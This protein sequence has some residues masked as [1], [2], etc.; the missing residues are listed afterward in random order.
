MY[1]SFFQLNHKPFE[2]VPNPSFLFMSSAHRKA[3]NYLTYGIRQQS[4]FI[5]LTGEVG[6]GKTT[7]IRGLIKSQLRDVVLSKV[8]NTK[9][10]SQQLLEMILEDFGVRP[11][12]KDK[13][14]LLRELNDFLIEQYSRGRQCVLI[15]DEAQNLTHELLE[16]V[17]LLSNLENDNQKLLR[18]ILVGQPELKTLL[19]S[20]KLLQL[21]QRVQVNCH[22]PPLAE[23]ETEQYIMHRLE[24]AGNRDA[25][26]FGPGAFEAVHG[27]TRG[28][29][30][31]INI[32]CDY[33]LLDAFAHETHDIS[34]QT[35]HEVAADLNFDN[36][37]WNP[38][39]VDEERE[40]AAPGLKPALA[41][42][43]Q[44]QAAQ[45]GRAQTVEKLTQLLGNLGA[46][47]K[48]I[49]E[50]LP[51]LAQARQEQA[52]DP[53]VL[54]T[55]LAAFQEALTPRFEEMWKAISNLSEES[56][57]CRQTPDE[58]VL[59]RQLAD[60]QKNLQARFEEKWKAVDEIAREVHALKN[61]VH[62]QGGLAFSAQG[63]APRAD[64]PVLQAKSAPSRGWMK[65]ILLGIL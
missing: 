27:Y 51:R 29:P 56:R 11:S 6:T 65:W 44:A 19:A 57:A 31:L 32:L 45:E 37:Y 62:F 7:L 8:F 22:I 5:L 58:E 17:R 35:V 3:L 38:P 43:A 12:G 25:A 33:L 64:K 50:V 26:H 24:L 20:P 48:S 30:R 52:V 39:E 28:V 16:E 49:E 21:R 9:V 55:Q 47:L 42:D 46:R 63:P 61:S 23:P 15:V 4:G 41:P 14:S 34:A 60:F 2:L 40:E 1:E 53:Q 13:P 54:K 10:R 36:Q 59:V 18:I